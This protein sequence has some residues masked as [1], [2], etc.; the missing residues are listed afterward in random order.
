MHNFDMVV[1][2]AR[3]SAIIDLANVPTVSDLRK[4]IVEEGKDA[5]FDLYDGYYVDPVLL[6]DILN[7]L[8]DTRSILLPSSK[9]K[10]CVIEGSNGEFA[11]LMPK[12]KVG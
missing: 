9:S 10:P 11:I 4:F 7:I 5:I 6:L 8:E 2:G 1:S 3:S 12:M